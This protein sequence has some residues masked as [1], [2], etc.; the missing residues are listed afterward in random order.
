M[1]GAEEIKAL[2]TAADDL[3][4]FFWVLVWSLVY[5]F[6]KVATITN[7]DSIILR[8]EAALSGHMFNDILRRDTLIRLSHD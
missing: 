5:I 3:E 7:E 2:H 8:L 1:P 4:S 6:K